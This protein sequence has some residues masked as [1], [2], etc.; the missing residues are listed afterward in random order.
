MF[1]Q[2]SNIIIYV[3]IVEKIRDLIRFVKYLHPGTG[4]CVKTGII[5]S[6]YYTISKTKQNY[7]LK[8]KL[9]RKH[10]QPIVKGQFRIKRLSNLN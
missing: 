5:A 1:W 10:G 8:K 2:F 9:K 7:N 3:K 4:W 6:F